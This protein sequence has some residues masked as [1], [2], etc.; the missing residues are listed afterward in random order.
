MRKQTQSPGHACCLTLLTL[1]IYSGALKVPRA[2]PLS[3]CSPCTAQHQPGDALWSLPLYFSSSA[4]ISQP[5]PRNWEATSKHMGDES[6]AGKHLQGAEVHLLLA[7]TSTKTH[8]PFP[9][10]PF[11][12]ASSFQFLFPSPITVPSFSSTTNSAEKREYLTLVQ[13]KADP[14]LH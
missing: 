12:R 1:W 2:H 8:I 10:W 7:E 9:N 5:V 11:C 3:K 4:P 13:G 6:L 14:K